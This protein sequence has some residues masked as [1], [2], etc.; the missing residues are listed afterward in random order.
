[1]LWL[2]GIPWTWLCSSSTRNYQV[3]YFT[4]EITCRNLPK[5]SYDFVFKTELPDRTTVLLPV[6]KD[7]TKEE[8]H[9]LVNGN[10]VD[11]ADWVR[12]WISFQSFPIENWKLMCIIFFWCFRDR[13]LKWMA[14][15]MKT[16]MEVTPITLPMAHENSASDIVLWSLSFGKFDYM[17]IDPEMQIVHF[18]FLASQVIRCLCGSF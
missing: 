3:W 7:R 4:S 10:G 17:I 13:E 6:S 8:N 9:K 15:F 12:I 11:P 16:A 5:F 18:Q 2:R 1:M 14:R